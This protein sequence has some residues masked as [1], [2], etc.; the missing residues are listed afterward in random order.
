MFEKLS[1]LMLH[2]QDGLWACEWC[3]DSLEMG[4]VCHFGHSFLPHF[5]GSPCAGLAVFS[6]KKVCCKQPSVSLRLSLMVTKHPVGLSR[7][8]T[9][10]ESTCPCRRHGRCRFDSWVR[11]IPWRRKWQPTTVFL[12]GESHGQRN[13]AG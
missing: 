4:R 1:F 2:L 12:P 10:K 7:W 11:K 8:H 6:P 13:L 9:G 5:L 3:E